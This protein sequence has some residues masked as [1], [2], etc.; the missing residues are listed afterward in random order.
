VNFKNVVIP[1]KELMKKYA[2]NTFA[3]YYPLINPNT[4]DIAS[5]A[6]QSRVVCATLD[7]FAALAMT[8]DNGWHVFTRSFAGMTDNCQAGQDACMVA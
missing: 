6:K 2:L 4:I 1:G 3:K 7:C 5:A 8:I